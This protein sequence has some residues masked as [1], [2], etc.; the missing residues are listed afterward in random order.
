MPWSHSWNKS[1]RIGQTWRKDLLIDWIRGDYWMK[2]GRN[3]RL[4][5]HFPSATGEL[6][7]IADEI[8]RYWPKWNRNQV[9]LQKMEQSLCDT[10]ET[11]AVNET[12]ANYSCVINDRWANHCSLSWGTFWGALSYSASRYRLQTFTYFSQF[13]VMDC[14]D[15]SNKVTNRKKKRRVET[16]KMIRNGELTANEL[17][18]EPTNFIKGQHNP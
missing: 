13:W 11:L 6:L 8:T 16:V 5:D 9:W 18:N 3:K 7:L 14:A 12:K 17:T 10:D 1:T 4:D 15:T 2:R